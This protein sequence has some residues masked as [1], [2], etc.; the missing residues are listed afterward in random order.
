M[1]QILQMKLQMDTIVN[2]KEIY[3]KKVTELEEQIEQ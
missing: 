2:E 3:K 1:E